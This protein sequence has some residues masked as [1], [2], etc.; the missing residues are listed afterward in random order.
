MNTQKLSKSVLVYNVD[1]IS[2]K[3]G[4]ISKVVN[5]ILC[6]KTYLEWTLL[7]IS[8]LDKQDLILDFIW[9]KAHNLEA[10]WQK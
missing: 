3:V 5:I 10:N 6:Y 2:N 1:S 7:T 4:Q 9:L 8:S